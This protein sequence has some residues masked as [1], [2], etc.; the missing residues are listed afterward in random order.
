[1]SSAAG[2]GSICWRCSGRNEDPTAL[3]EETLAAAR[4]HANPY[5]VAL[6]LW[7]SGDMRGAAGGIH[8][9]LVIPGYTLGL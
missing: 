9:H 1:M 2:R 6:A 4:A 8:T 5:F 7:V 3:A